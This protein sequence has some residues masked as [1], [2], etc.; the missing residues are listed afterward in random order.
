MDLKKGKYTVNVTYGGNENFTGNNTTQKL[1]IKEEIVEE[2]VVQKSTQSSSQSTDLYYDEEI[3]VYYDGNGKI[4][5]PDGQHPQGVGG[6]YSNVR[7]AQ[8]RWNR[9][10]P[11]MV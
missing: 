8:D 4:V 7:E 6:S 3:N 2:P 11:V 10:E 5:D 1:K 9:G